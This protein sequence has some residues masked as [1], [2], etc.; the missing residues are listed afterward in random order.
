MLSAVSAILFGF[1]RITHDA[2][3]SVN[4]SIQGT[5]KLWSFAPCS[6]A[7]ICKEIKQH[8]EEEKY[9]KKVQS[10]LKAAMTKLKQLEL[11]IML[12]KDN[13]STSLT[14]FA[15]EVQANLINSDPKKYRRTTT[16]GERV[17]QWLLVNTDIRKLERICNSKVPYRSEMQNFSVNMTSVSPSLADKRH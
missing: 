6:S 13:Y 9:F 5:T 17:L 7:T 2:T 11:D 10:E 14:T 16:T 15:A 8:P 12:K 1:A 3:T 4:P